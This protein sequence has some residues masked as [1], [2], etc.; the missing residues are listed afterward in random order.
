MIKVV[1]LSSNGFV[2][3]AY[4]KGIAVIKMGNYEGKW[5][6]ECQTL[7]FSYNM[8]RRCAVLQS[9]PKK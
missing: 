1:N 5:Q 7:S 2:D 9:R 3:W 8:V 6:V 4:E